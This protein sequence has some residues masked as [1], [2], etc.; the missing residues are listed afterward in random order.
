[1]LKKNNIISI[2]FCFIFLFSG[3]VSAADSYRVVKISDGDTFTATDGWIR[4]KV[5]IAAIDTP[6][7]KQPYGKV[8]KYHLSQL[9]KGKKVRLSLLK[10]GLDRYNRI[11]AHVYVG[12]TNV[13]MTMIEKGLAHYYRPDCKDYPYNKAKYDYE[14]ALYVAAEKVAKKNRHNIWSLSSPE[15]PCKYRRKK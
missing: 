12:E 7:Y 13:G 10:R 11:L 14:P 5:R 2:L 1:M 8:A 3:S 9:I 4:F 6:E 15:K